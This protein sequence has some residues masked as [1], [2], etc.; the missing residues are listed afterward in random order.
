M[1][2]SAFDP[3]R[4]PD[5]FWARD[6]VDWVLDRRD[7]AALFRLL[8]KHLGASQTRIGTATGLAQGTVCAIMKGTRQVI[9]LDVLERI[10]DGLAMPDTARIRLG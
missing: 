9:A 3:I 2:S 6:E 1:V 8:S 10:A 5:E 4:I 7:F